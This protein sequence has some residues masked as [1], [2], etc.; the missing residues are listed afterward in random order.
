[1]LSGRLRNSEE[2]IVIQEVIEKHFKRKIDQSSLFGWG[3]SK[4]GVS[5]V[6]SIAMLRG[7]LPE[8]F[9]HIV[10]TPELMRMGVLVHRAVMF[11]EPV[12]L[13]GKTG[14]YIKEYF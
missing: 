2:I 4:G 7:P 1:M 10:W 6:E 3:G 14:Y 5:T 8:E 11:Q 13:V 12:L 9:E